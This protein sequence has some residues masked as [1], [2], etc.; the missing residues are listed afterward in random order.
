MLTSSPRWRRATSS[1]R[2]RSASRVVPAATPTVD[3]LARSGIRSF[4]HDGV[5]VLALL[6]YTGLASA[7][8]PDELETPG[9]SWL[10]A[11]ASTPSGQDQTKRCARSGTRDSTSHAAGHRDPHR[12]AS[13]NWR[14]AAVGTR[15]VRPS[16]DAGDAGTSSGSP[17][18]ASKS[19]GRVASDPQVDPPPP[20][21][22]STSGSPRLRLPW[23]SSF[24]GGAACHDVRVTSPT[25]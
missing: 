12:L 6:R 20:S 22:V 8:P 19:V 4:V 2:S 9:R 17:P 10:E 1:L 13:R 18:F 25:P 24:V 21:M 5:E 15:S 11:S 23:S 7:P 16:F 3:V 14:S